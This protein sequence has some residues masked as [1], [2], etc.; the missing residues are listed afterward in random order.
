MPY[1][2]DDVPTAESQLDGGFCT[3]CGQALTDPLG[4]I[5]LAG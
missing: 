4:E 2:D 1:P 5:E 3:Y